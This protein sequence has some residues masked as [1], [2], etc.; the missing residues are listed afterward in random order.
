MSYLP[1]TLGRNVVMRDDIWLQD[2]T[3]TKRVYSVNR[4]PVSSCRRA[5][6][7]SLGRPFP[8]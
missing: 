8:D 3:G 6:T 5:A 1:G 2:T 4:L 7:I